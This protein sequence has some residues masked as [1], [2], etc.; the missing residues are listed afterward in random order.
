MSATPASTVS[1]SDGLEA[2]LS[3]RF[4]VV[5]T[6][7][8]TG[9]ATL[10]I[11]HPANADD[12]ITEEDYVRDERM[13]YWAD[14][15]P[16]ALVLSS[17]VAG[18]TGAGRRL[19]ELGCGAGLVTTAA[20][21]AGYDVLATDYYEDALLFARANVQRNGGHAV[22]TRMVDWREFPEDL[23]TFDRVIASD[24]L[25]EMTYAPL[26]ARAIALSL[27]RDGVAVVADPGRVAVPAFER[28][29]ASVGLA[30]ECAA[31]VPFVAGEIRQT[32][33]IWEIRRA[34]H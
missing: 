18:E 6:P 31:R 16:S 24:I 22:R 13:P 30:I 20:V 28:E 21:L 19:L 15:W 11:L 8:D 29:C 4:R 23:G 1:G 26:V 12:L 2:E 34:P 25:Y 33:D 14:L 5:D 32:I 9:L 7:I 3:R 10:R 17:R 27:G